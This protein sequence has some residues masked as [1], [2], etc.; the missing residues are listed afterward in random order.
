MRICGFL[1]FAEPHCPRSSTA[2]PGRPARCTRPRGHSPED[3]IA[4][5]A[6]LGYAAGLLTVASYV[7]QVVRVW[8]TKE[9]KDLSYGMFG[10]L[11]SAAALWITYGMLSEQWPVIATNVGCGLLN[12]AI[13]AAKIRFH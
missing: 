10:M 1:P 13:L 6:Y 9:T 5:V 12:V 11:V 2:A 4:A 7:P 8:R 3:R